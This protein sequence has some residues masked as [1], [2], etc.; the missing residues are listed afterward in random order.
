M[1][2]GTGKVGGHFG[3]M[4]AVSGPWAN[5]GGANGTIKFDGESQKCHLLVPG[6]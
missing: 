5:R 2:V 3:G 6:C 4:L 1:L